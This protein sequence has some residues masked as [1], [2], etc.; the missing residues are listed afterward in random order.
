[1]VPAKPKFSTFFLLYYYT[2]SSST[3]SLNNEVSRGITVATT[4]NPFKPSPS[5]QTKRPTAQSIG[6]NL[7][8]G[9]TS[10]AAEAKYWAEKFGFSS[11]HSSKSTAQFAHARK[12]TLQ[13]TS[14]A[15]V[16]Q[17]VFSPLSNAPSNSNHCSLAVVSGPR[18]Q[19]YG[20]AP[21]SSFHR[22]L[23][24]HST[25]TSE[26]SVA[27][28]RQ[29]PTGGNLAISARFRHDGQLL[30]IGTENGQLRIVSLASRATLCTFTAPS[31]LSIRSLAWFRSGQY[32]LAAGDDGV[33]RI[34]QLSQAAT[35]SSSLDASVCVLKGHGDAI[36]SCVL[37]QQSPRNT[38]TTWPYQRL[39]ATG[40]YDHTIRIWNVQDLEKQDESDNDHSRCLSI[41]NHGCPVEA[42]AMMPSSSPDLPAWLVSAGGTTVK[43]WNLFTGAC[44]STTNCQH[45]KSI[46]S[47]LAVSTRST[48]TTT[49]DDDID[50]SIR[51]VTAGLDGFLRIHAWDSFNGTIMLLHGIK[52][53][54]AITSLGVDA[55]N[56]RL[57]VGTASGK[58]LVRQN[59]PSLTQHK[60]KR[61]PRAGTYAYFTRGM[62]VAAATGDFVVS[63]PP[64]KKRKLRSFDVALRE[65]RYGDAL[66]DALESRIPQVVVAVLEELGKRRGLTIALSNRDEESLEPILSFTVRYICRPRFA[67]LLIGVA[68]KL[69]DIYADISG[70]SET[71]DELF[72]KLTTSE[73]T[74][75]EGQQLLILSLR[76][77]QTKEASERGSS[78]S[79]ETAS[80]CR[81]VGRHHGV[82]R[83]RWR[84]S[85]VETCKTPAADL[86][87]L[88]QRLAFEGH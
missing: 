88:R 46:T 78:S 62:N 55:S 24:R 58:V 70:Q 35:S 33:A 3:R 52:V 48:Q 4:T 32:V 81:T 83:C 76:Y 42:L 22:S 77:R 79:A 72:G 39:A 17:V 13:A 68:N 11:K 49:K 36:R 63:G 41:L 84:H 21:L 71:I 19:L 29:I 50:T 85:R 1:M 37:W 14:A 64:G 44:V 47:L 54:D 26:Q 65:F 56:G 74:E 34:W 60:R 87:G 16:H 59:G 18:V 38:T 12:L 31:T 9:T 15:I 45:S 73:Q 5:L 25:V 69:I 23:Q 20:T 10:N 57:A 28:D 75:N 30:A 40:S 86:S 53:N 6:D 27:P 80:G 2:M 67:A 82:H 8:A 51:L 66:D 61:E 43:V 7:A